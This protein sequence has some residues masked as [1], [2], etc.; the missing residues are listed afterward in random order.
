MLNL[1]TKEQFQAETA[2]R[3]K[4]RSSAL[5]ALDD[6]LGAYQKNPG[7]MTEKAVRKA[8]TDW[9]RQ[10]GENWLTSDRNMPPKFPITALDNELKKN[11]VFDEKE[12]A[13]IQEL[14]RAR[15]NSIQQ[16]FANAD[17]NLRI[18]NAMQQTRQAFSELKSTIAEA[19]KGNAGNTARNAKNLAINTKANI[20]GDKLIYAQGHQAA[21]YVGG[22]L[23]AGGQAGEQ[24][25]EAAGKLA[26]SQQLAEIKT[27]LQDLFGE[28]IADVKNF[29]LNLLA[30]NGLSGILATA[31]HVADMIPFICLVSGGAKA[32]VAA[33][34]VVKTAYDE[35]AFSRHGFAIEKGAPAAAFRA[36]QVLLARE[37]A[38][39]AA[40]A[41]IETATFAANTALHAA[42]GAG[43][44]AA[45]LVKAANATA[46]AIRVITM[47]AIQIRET[48]IAR[49]LLKDPKN[50]DLNMFKKAP[51]LG[52][53]MLVGSTTSDLVAM[54][55]ENFG[56]TGWMDDIENLAKKH[57]EPVLKQCESLIQ[58]S[59]FI[60]T[61]IPM[62]RKA[63]G[64]STITTFVTTML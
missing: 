63:T 15:N 40:K 36:V 7:P 52:A 54:L 23:S 57:I 10:K 27:A 55:F 12:K 48:L 44:I 60:V 3:G 56:Q 26:F 31:Q 30:E 2:L 11:L 32:L 20:A 25:L 53:Y 24:G 8:F 47:F 39:A 50:L 17:I 22:A 5:R 18:F 28:P 35:I 14:I 29:I 49:R 6:A 4:M 16:I 51:L 61:G 42:K 13:A 37:I 43:S 19:R 62:H 33:G 9:K 59:A 21:G 45:P 64:V 41:A 46:N 58:S 38:N 34:K 1:P